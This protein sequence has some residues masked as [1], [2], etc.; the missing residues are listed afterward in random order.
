MCGSVAACMYVHRVAVHT[1]AATRT[2]F[3]RETSARDRPVCVHAPFFPHADVVDIVAC[4]QG[5]PPHTYKG[6][7]G[8]RT[9]ARTHARRRPF[10]PMCARTR[11]KQQSF[12]T[13]AVARAQPNPAPIPPRAAHSNARSHKAAKQQGFSTQLNLAQLRPRMHTKLRRKFGGGYN[14]RLT[15]VYS[16]FFISLTATKLLAAHTYVNDVLLS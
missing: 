7:K 3:A 8:P 14:P 6:R 4:G 13:R 1:H 10:W 12:S 9:H 5:A 15:S 2:Q 16:M 11:T